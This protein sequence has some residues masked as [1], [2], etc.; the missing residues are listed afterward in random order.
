MAA[1]DLQVTHQ[2]AVIGSSHSGRPAQARPCKRGPV[3]LSGPRL[4]AGSRSACACGLA[5]RLPVATPGAPLKRG[6]GGAQAIA[7]RFHVS[8]ER[9]WRSG[10]GPA[11]AWAQPLVARNVAPTASASDVRATRFLACAWR[12]RTEG[13]R[14]CTSGLRPRLYQ[15]RSLSLRRGRPQWYHDSTSAPREARIYWGSE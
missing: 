15:G 7:R 6:G 12:M 10:D 9:A 8:C 5:G 11:E 4:R 1:S 13:A 2:P 14:R 3:A